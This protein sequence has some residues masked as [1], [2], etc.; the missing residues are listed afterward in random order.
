M[1]IEYAMIDTTGRTTCRR[2]KRGDP[3]TECLGRC[4]GLSTKLHATCDALGNPTGFHLPDLAGV[5]VD[6]VRLV[7]SIIE[8]A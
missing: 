3:T 8:F 7:L 4:G 2:G 6:L 1:R 5:E